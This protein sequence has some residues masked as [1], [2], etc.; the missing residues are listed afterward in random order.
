MGTTLTLY[1]VSF[2]LPLPKLALP[3]SI[4]DRPPRPFLSLS[5][6]HRRLRR[7]TYTIHVR[8][9]RSL[10]LEHTIRLPHYILTLARLGL[11]IHNSAL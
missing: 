8:P 4:H 5:A 7:S 10:L 1:L 6:P 11:T 2:L 3:V 9:T